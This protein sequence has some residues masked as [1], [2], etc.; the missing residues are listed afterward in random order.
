LP[1]DRKQL[2]RRN[3]MGRAIVDRRAV[4]SRKKQKL[5]EQSK[6]VAAA[7]ETKQK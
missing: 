5:D 7:T 4:A 1:N 2:K 6:Q 3:K